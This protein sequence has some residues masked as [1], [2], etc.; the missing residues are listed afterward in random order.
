MSILTYVLVS[1]SDM[2]L[3]LLQVCH[4]LDIYRD[5]RDERDLPLVLETNSVC[6]IFIWDL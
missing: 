2:N 5:K 1:S 3:C 4:D 6:D